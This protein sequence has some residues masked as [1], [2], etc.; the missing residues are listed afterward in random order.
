MDA[1][2]FVT[3][4]RYIQSLFMMESTFDRARMARLIVLVNMNKRIVLRIPINHPP[5]FA[6]VF[7]PYKFG[8]CSLHPKQTV[9]LIPQYFKPYSFVTNTY[10]AQSRIRSARDGAWKISRRG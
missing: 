2:H 7:A 6:F 10:S 1:I 8:K 3:S 9:I 5:V 4:N